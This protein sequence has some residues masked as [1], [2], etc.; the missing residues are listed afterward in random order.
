MSLFRRSAL[1]K[2]SSPERLD[3][4]MTAASPRHWIAFLSAFIIVAGAVA[5]GFLGSIPTRL[6]AQGI[7]LSYGGEIFSATSEGDGLLTEV[8]V[9]TGQRVEKGQR[10]ATLDLRLDQSRLE[11]EHE[12]L[13]NLDERR[14]AY[15]EQRE[16]DLGKR[17]ALRDL[18][19]ESLRQ[20]VDNNE[21]RSTVL[22]ERLSDL[23]SLHRDGH[24]NRQAI[25]AAESEWLQ[26][27]ETAS[28]LRTEIVNL[29]VEIH[30]RREYWADRIRQVET[31]IFNHGK[32]IEE[33]EER[34]SAARHLRSP[35]SGHVTEIASSL[36]DRITTGTPVIR[37][38]T[39]SDEL[40]ALLFVTP[41]LGKRIRTGFT[42]NVEP[43]VTKKEEFGTVRGVV[44][45][46]SELPLSSSAIN[47]LLHND[48]LVEQFTANGAPVAVRADLVE[49]VTTASGLAWTSGTGPDFD[50][51]NGTLVSATITTAR[52]APVTLILPFLKSVLGVDL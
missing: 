3:E 23:K 37:V 29:D 18:R 43:T 48:K 15:I 51:E 36:G 40:D 33:I 12:K 49:D 1:E 6:H 21:H 22:S 45:S 30:D 31:E 25:L 10:L 19:A 17:L 11:R 38:I 2:M 47:S 20:R 41:D 26:A 7:L 46:V 34:I 9:T 14:S 32:T 44:R 24:V 42:V 13:E 16:A 28:A 39:D 52:Q 5:W 35:V 50:I 27:K 4:A 8:L